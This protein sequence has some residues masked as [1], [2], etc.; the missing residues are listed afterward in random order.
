[1][2]SSV[3]LGKKK[4]GGWNENIIAQDDRLYNTRGGI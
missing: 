1:M 3:F 4:K 2:R